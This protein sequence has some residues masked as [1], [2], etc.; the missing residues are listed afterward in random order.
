M[1]DPTSWNFAPDRKI[2][3]AFSS[4]EAGSFD[5]VRYS[6]TVGV[7]HTRRD[8]RPERQFAFFENHLSINP[9]ISIYHNAE[10]D[11][12][13]RGLFAEDLTGLMLT[14]S[15][16]T[17]RARVNDVVSFDISHNH[18]RG[19][20]TFDTRLLGAGLL[21]QFLFQGVSGGVR[22]QLPARS[23][24][25]AN[26]GR[27]SQPTDEKPSWNY[28]LGLT[29]GRVPNLWGIRA[30]FRA[31]R[32]HSSFGEGG[33][34]TIS[35][36]REIRESMRCE[37][38]GGQQSFFSPLTRQNR[39]R[40]ITSYFDWFFTQHYMLGLGF[41]DFRGRVQAYRQFFI[42]VGYRF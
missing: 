4:V 36:S 33:Y 41:T 8:W 1:P 24:L 25:Y 30:D 40:W 31:S 13:T 26:F 9:E 27:S 42:N 18:F 38:Q 21:D 7:A 2:V 11:N 28:L 17:F 35:F 23:A 16:L 37:V 29:L 34:N 12:R 6:S 39:S 10:V 15:F 20:P 14:R 5:N 22:F 19:T 32:F 3:G